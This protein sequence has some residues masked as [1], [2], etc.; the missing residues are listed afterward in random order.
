MR[1]N[2]N[3]NSNNN[4]T[5]QVNFHDP[6]HN[7]QQQQRKQMTR[8]LKLQPNNLHISMSNQD[9]EE[10]ETM[11]WKE[12]SADL[13]F[14]QTCPLGS[15]SGFELD[16]WEKK[17]DANKSA[18]IPQGSSSLDDNQDDF[19][20]T[21]QDC[22]SVYS[23]EEQ[24]SSSISYSSSEEKDDDDE[25]DDT[26]NDSNDGIP[27]SNQRQNSS[28]CCP[29]DDPPKN[30]EEISIGISKSVPILEPLFQAAVDH[31]GV[32]HVHF[33]ATVVTAEY[34][35]EKPSDDDFFR[36]YYSAHELQRLRDQYKIDISCAATTSRSSTSPDEEKTG[37][38]G[39][40]LDDSANNEANQ[41]LC[42]SD[43]YPV[44]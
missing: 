42:A 37:I 33:G 30:V 19:D 9:E 21:Q 36:L 16:C 23:E 6:T 11:M 13:E 10:E 43:D 24:D 31:M 34:K 2:N 41:V 26:E 20:W 5:F 18:M 12:E 32:R 15:S 22:S 17:S 3:N 14:F 7:I 40:Q 28:C 8:A 1:K 44:W 27:Q 38:F 39:K 35:Y 4:S 25:E 29:S